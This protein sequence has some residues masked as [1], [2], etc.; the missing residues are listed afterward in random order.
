[1]KLGNE[2]FNKSIVIL[3]EGKTDKIFFEELIK[4]IGRESDIQV[5]D[6]KGKDRLKSLIKFPDFSLVKIL[7]VV[8]DADNDP[9]RAFQSIRDTLKNSGFSIPSKPYEVSDGSLKTAIIILPDENE[10]GD[11]ESLI[12]EHLKNRLEFRCVDGF[13]NCVKNFNFDLKKLSKTKLY[14]Y[15]SITS[16]PDANFDTFIKKKIIDF[17]NERF[18]KLIDFIKSLQP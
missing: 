17:T 1:L 10:K 13:V 11:L 18:K 12:V 9:K 4:F 7:V 3:I 6:M 2:K 16:E 14:A 8:Q 15:I 5:V